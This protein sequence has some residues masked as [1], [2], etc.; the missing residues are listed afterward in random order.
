MAS[1]TEARVSS[2]TGMEKEISSLG[3][4]PPQERGNLLVP[5][6]AT[7]L[8]AASTRGTSSGGAN[9]NDHQDESVS[10]TLLI[11]SSQRT[12]QSNRNFQQVLKM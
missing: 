2:S 11:D 5:A 3:S 1:I 8:M 10:L 9:L 6:S 4:V 7:R 12:F